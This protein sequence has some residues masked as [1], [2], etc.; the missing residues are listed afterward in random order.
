MATNTSFDSLEDFDVDMIN[1][2]E[3]MESKNNATVNTK[4]KPLKIS[5]NRPLRHKGRERVSIFKNEPVYCTH[6]LL[7]Y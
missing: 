7:F 5:L 2:V 4:G 1:A 3:Q 6:I